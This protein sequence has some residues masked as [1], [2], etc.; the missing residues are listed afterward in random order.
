MNENVKILIV[1]DEERLRESLKKM[2]EADGFLVETAED[3]NAG[4]SALLDSSFDVAIVDL[5]MPKRDG[6]WL[7]GEINKKN[8]DVSVVVATGYGTVELVVKAMKKGA[9]DFIQKPVDYEL[10]KVI[11][12][13]AAERRGAVRAQNDAEKRIKQQNEELKEV[14]DKLK[15]LDKLKTDFL[16]MA[17]HELRTP[18]TVISCALEIARSEIAD[19]NISG[20]DMHIN[21][22][23]EFSRN[24]NSIVNEML[25]LNTIESGN[26]HG[27]ITDNDL[28]EIVSSAAGGTKA[29]LNKKGIALKVD[30]TELSKNV[31][32]SKERV[33]QVVVNL[34]G[35]AVKF[36]PEGGEIA[37]SVREGDE[38]FITSVKDTGC[39]IAPEDLEHIFEEFFQVRRGSH[40]GAGLGLAICRKIIDG[41][42]GRIWAESEPGRGT[43][44]SFSLPLK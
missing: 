30:T 16:S 43:T 39:G 32:C 4:L 5:V 23:L 27:E 2:L 31:K 19:G 14:N 38:G 15:E 18:L 1:D 11:V 22:A 36:T 29:L 40:C 10:M 13:K 9:W 28:S 6:M 21:N 26:L 35:N 44:I 3:G 37:V 7:I 17:V 24:M 34:I 33:S 20:I 25:D 12:D 8:I 42:G 41:H